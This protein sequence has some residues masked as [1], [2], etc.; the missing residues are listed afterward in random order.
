MHY[1][2]G[3]FSK[4]RKAVKFHSVS[5][6]PKSYWLIILQRIFS[7]VAVKDIINSGKKVCYVMTRVPAR[8]MHSLVD[9]K[10]LF[11]HLQFFIISRFPQLYE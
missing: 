1:T 7:V 8:R 3:Y 2:Y 10:D 11:I 5:I 4:L 9:L 6:S